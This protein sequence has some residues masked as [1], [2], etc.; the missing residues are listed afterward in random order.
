M[1]S[2]SWD[3]K[4]NLQALAKSV[5]QHR[6]C[7][8]CGEVCIR[9]AHPYLAHTVLQAQMEAS[10]DLGGADC[11]GCVVLLVPSQAANWFAV[12]HGGTDALQEGWE[13]KS[14]EQRLAG[15]VDWNKWHVEMIPLGSWRISG[16]L[17]F[18]CLFVCLFV[19]LKE[20]GVPVRM[21]SR[22]KSSLK[23][24]WQALGIFL[25]LPKHPRLYWQ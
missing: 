16:R 23:W 6:L 12:V 20:E 18:I 15:H 19:D 24:C 22:T 11:V 25:T 21:K 3:T 7:P 4:H 9:C 8:M 13:L 17:A 2:D 1:F 14:P 10:A 5:K